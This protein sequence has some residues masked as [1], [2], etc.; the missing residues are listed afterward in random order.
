MESRYIILDF[1]RCPINCPES[2]CKILDKVDGFQKTRGNITDKVLEDSG[3]Y[4]R[5]IYNEETAVMVYYNYN[6]TEVGFSRDIEEPIEESEKKISEAR[7][8]LNEL[9]KNKE[10]ILH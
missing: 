10:L 7:K 8:Y 2:I 1:G 6:I 5:Y 3:A 4:K 9:L